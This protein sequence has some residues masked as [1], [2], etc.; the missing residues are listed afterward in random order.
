MRPAL[1]VLHVNVLLF[2]APQAFERN[3]GGSRG[4]W[5]C[6]ILRLP[7]VLSVQWIS[8]M[9]RPVGL[10]VVERMGEVAVPRPR[11]TTQP[12]QPA[13]SWRQPRAPLHP[14]KSARPVHSW[15]SAR[16]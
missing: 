5:T 2:F 15:Q 10:R 4:L 6:I 7:V 14:C 11:G 16:F 13:R 9:T 8:I 12:M 3:A 1:C